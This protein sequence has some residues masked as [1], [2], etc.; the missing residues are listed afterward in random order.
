MTTGLEKFFEEKR[1]SEQ[2]EGK[3]GVGWVI[4]ELLRNF[5]RCH[6]RWL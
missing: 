4:L 3:K 2:E 1:D 5:E 6:F